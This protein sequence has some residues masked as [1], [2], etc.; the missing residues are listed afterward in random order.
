MREITY[1]VSAYL[2]SDIAYIFSLVAINI[3]PSLFIYFNIIITIIYKS[4][5]RL[6]SAIIFYRKGIC[7]VIKE[8]EERYNLKEKLNGSIFPSY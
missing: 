7:R 1:K 6:Y 8:K 3:L 5:Y 2:L 4:L